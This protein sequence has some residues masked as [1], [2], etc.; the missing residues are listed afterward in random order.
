M[1]GDDDGRMVGW[2]GRV[3]GGVAADSIVG[4]AAPVTRVGSQVAIGWARDRVASI[5]R[6]YAK[7]Q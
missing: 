2:A 3:W 6:I 7:A 5:R 4:R 1:L